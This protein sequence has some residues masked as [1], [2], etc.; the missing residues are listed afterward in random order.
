MPLKDTGLSGR[1]QLHIDYAANRE[2]YRSGSGISIILFYKNKII[3]Q[4]FP[5]CFIMLTG[6]LES[7]IKPKT[8]KSNDKEKRSKPQEHCHLGQNLFHS[9]TP[10]DNVMISCQGPSMR[11]KK[12]KSLH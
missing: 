10:D 9:Q 3:D 1:P 11:C 5:V 7:L 4:C 12:R 8:P 6:L 2:E